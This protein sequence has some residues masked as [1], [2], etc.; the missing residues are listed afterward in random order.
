[1]FI[2]LITVSISICIRFIF[3]PRPELLCLC[4]NTKLLVEYVL[5]RVRDLPA[6]GG[7]T[8]GHPNQMTLSP[9]RGAID[10]GVP[11]VE[12][13]EI[14]HE[15]YITGLL[16]ELHG[17]VLGEL[18]ELFQR[19]VLLRSQYRGGPGAGTEGRPLEEGARESDLDFVVTTVDDR[20]VDNYRLSVFATS[21]EMP[22]VRPGIQVTWESAAMKKRGRST[23]PFRIFP[24]PILC[25]K[26][27]SFWLVL[28]HFIV[29]LPEACK[30]DV[31]A[32]TARALNI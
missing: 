16:G 24:G 3:R 11:G 7:V 27:E 1:M 26:F 25:Q 18:K 31:T 14:V 22:C 29:E 13:G 9:R 20:S 10:K 6:F 28:N 21:K 23:V 17:V 8:N 32:L 5:V 2:V 4:L 12:N 15:H 19:T 30:V